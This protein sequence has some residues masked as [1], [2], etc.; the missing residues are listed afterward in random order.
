MEGAKDAA[1]E[2]QV[3]DVP[4]ESGATHTGPTASGEDSPPT[5]QSKL[6]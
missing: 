6:R 4:T 2:R 1:R 3:A 5:E